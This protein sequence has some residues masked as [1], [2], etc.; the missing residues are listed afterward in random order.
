MSQLAM[1]NE[2]HDFIEYM[3]HTKKSSGNTEVSYERDL[4]KMMQFLQE[5]CQV[6]DSSKVTE[7]NLNS[8]MLY[9]FLLNHV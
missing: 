5:E 1:E 9:Y 7:T 6:S 8:Y 3:H 4:R 2:I